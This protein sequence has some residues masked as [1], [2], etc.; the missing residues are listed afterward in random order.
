M[1]RVSCRFKAITHSKATEGGKL[2]SKANLSFTNN[3]C[4]QQKGHHDY[5][6]GS[7][8]QPKEG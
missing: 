8:C 1:A 7:D 4:Y 2:A 5:Q 6:L 3:F